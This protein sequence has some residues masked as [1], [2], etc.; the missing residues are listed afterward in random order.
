MEY[1]FAVARE[2]IVWLMP[3]FGMTKLSDQRKIDRS[4]TK[5]TTT[6]SASLFSL[7]FR[8]QILWVRARDLNAK[9]VRIFKGTFLWLTRKSF[10][11]IRLSLSHSR[12]ALMAYI[13]SGLNA[14][15]DDDQHNRH[16]LPI[17]FG[18]SIGTRGLKLPSKANH[19]ISIFLRFHSSEENRNMR[20]AHDSSNYQNSKCFRYD[21]L[22]AHFGNRKVHK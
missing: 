16:R 12:S 4:L 9:S 14:M 3:H 7:L 5:T 1:W 10:D 20:E 11:F 2:T 21:T 8:R 18:S 6:K 13:P 22:S 15:P 17:K 19:D